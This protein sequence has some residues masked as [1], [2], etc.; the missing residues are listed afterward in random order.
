MAR[1]S[2][3]KSAQSSP[4]DADKDR[5]DRILDVAI[6]LAEEGGFE[7]VRQRDVAQQAG[8]ALGTL[9]KSFRGKEDLL[10]AALE[11]ETEV[12]EKRL[13]RRPPS[14]STALARV[15]E[16]FDALTR[17]MCK[18]PNYAR[19]IIKAMASGEPEV[20][21][22]IVA[23]QSHIYRMLVSAMRGPDHPEPEGEP[24]ADELAVALLLQQVWFAA[25]VGWSAKLHGVPRIIEQ[26]S[27]AMRL[28]LAGL[29]VER[30]L[31]ARG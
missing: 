13:D 17:T 7:N 21:S 26:V 19:A 2:R 28:L 31:E 30:R 4:V 11:R 9:Y 5:R 8:V 3:A 24:T 12:L 27:V 29:A 15:T 14:G 18:K 16:F 1:R 10:S 22:N 23:Y 25:L 6:R 20:A